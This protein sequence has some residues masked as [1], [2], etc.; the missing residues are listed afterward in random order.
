MSIRILIFCFA[1]VLLGS[2]G[3]QCFKCEGVSGYP[4]STICKDTYETTTNDQ[5]PSWAE[6]QETA[7]SAGCVK[8]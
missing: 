3:D 8:Q 1:L 4:N 7:V 5:S 2:C 6:Y